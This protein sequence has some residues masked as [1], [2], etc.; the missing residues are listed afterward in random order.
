LTT[1]FYNRTWTGSSIRAFLRQ[2]LEA[3]FADFRREDLENKF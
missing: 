2:G 3:L 1:G